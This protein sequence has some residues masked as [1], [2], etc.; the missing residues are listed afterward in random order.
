M[1]EEG[2]WVLGQGGFETPV[3]LRQEE[4]EAFMSDML[5]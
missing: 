5:T 4:Q 2:T 1:L 3:S